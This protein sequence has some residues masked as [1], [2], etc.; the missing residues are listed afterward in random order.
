MFWATPYT[1][2][3]H[4][5]SIGGVF[6]VLL[7]LALCQSFFHT[8]VGDVIRTVPFECLSFH[9]VPFVARCLTLLIELLLRCMCTTTQIPQK[10]KASSSKAISPIGE[11]ALWLYPILRFVCSLRRGLNCWWRYGS[12][13]NRAHQNIIPS[14]LK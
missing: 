2:Q 11:W 3:I 7:S 8:A 6:F 10:K 9:R 4:A 5:R 1:A 14:T 12:T 13:R